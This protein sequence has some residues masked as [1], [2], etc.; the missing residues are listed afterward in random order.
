MSAETVQIDALGAGGDGIARTDSGAVF[1]PFTC[2]GDTVKIAREK[3]HGTII[4]LTD[5]SPHR[6]QPACRHFGP[7][8]ENG[9]C[10]GCSVQH[11]NDATYQ[12]FKRDLVVMAMKSKGIDCDIDPLITCQPGERRRAVFAARRT[13]KGLLLGFNQASSH[14]IVAISE[15]PVIHDSII[16]KLE[17]IRRIGLSLATDS[18]VFRISVLTTLTG[19]DIAVDGL[20]KL[21]EKQRHKAIETALSVKGL[22]RLSVDS[23]ILVEP[24]KPTLKFGSADISPPPGA[25]V[26]ATLSAENVMAEMVCNI[27][28]K[29]K[30]VADLFCG[31]GTFALRLATKAKVH[32]VEM[33]EKPLAALQAGLRGQ[34]GLKPVTVERRDLFRRPL[35]AQELKKFDAVVFD[36]PRAGA[37]SQVKE[38]ARAKVPK[39]AAISCNPVSLARDLLLLV[40]AGYRIKKITPVDQFLWSP[41]VEVVACVEYAR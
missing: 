10:G 26:Q 37:E 32:A 20:R 27:V 33:E 13:E 12:T 2:P 18:A 1:I 11:L 25:F 39:I 38:L 22:A 36:P 5:S 7:D 30:S 4:A 35:T 3:N 34:Q 16:G 24:I 40:D 28:G 9:T 23:E 19:L 29:S 21:P 31:S 6:R 15:C 41:H 14:H 8:G 17:D